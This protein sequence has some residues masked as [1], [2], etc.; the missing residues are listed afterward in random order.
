MRRRDFT[1]FVCG[2]MLAPP[3]RAAAQQSGRTHRVGILVG[4]EE[5]D[6][7]ERK[8]IAAVRAGLAE[9]GWIEGRNIAFEIRYVGGRLDRVPA[10]VAELLSANIEL[11]VTQ[12]T[13]LTQDVQK[14]SPNTPIVMAG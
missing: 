13:E 9:R 2:V 12:G 4:G 14:A 11:I 5:H 10:L 3:L 8:R 1:A 6:A 7:L